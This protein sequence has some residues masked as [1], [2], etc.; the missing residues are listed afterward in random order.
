MS[1][2][3]TPTPTMTDLA[4]LVLAHGRILQRA[5]NRLDPVRRDK[6]WALGLEGLHLLLDSIDEIDEDDDSGALAEG[7]DPDWL[8]P[9]LDRGQPVPA[10]L[11]DP[12]VLRDAIR[13][14]GLRAEHAGRDRRRRAAAA[15][16]STLRS[17]NLKAVAASLVDQ[18]EVM[19]ELE[20]DAG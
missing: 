10:D 12:Q 6:D 17:G 2:V 9:D 14:E 19:L 20:E 1:T 7:E 15:L 5:A 16:L 3:Q 13:L 4:D 18:F 11:L 8:I